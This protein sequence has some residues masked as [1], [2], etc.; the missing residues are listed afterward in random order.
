MIRPLLPGDLLYILQA[1]QWTVLLSL[2]AMGGGGALA[3]PVMLARLSRRGAL[4]LAA[5]AYIQFFQGTPLLMQVFLAFFG[6]S[7]VGVRPSPWTAASLAFSLYSSAYL[8]DI[9]RGCVQAVPRGQWEAARSLALGTPRT[10]LLVVGPQAARIAVAPTVGF[11]VQVVKSTSLASIIGFTELMRAGQFI[12]NAT[13]RPLLVYGFVACV[14][15]L[16]CWP[17]TLASR[18]L[19]A[20]FRRAGSAA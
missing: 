8:A 2:V 14:F 15:Y 9:W 20:R 6:P 17:L 12:T 5:V 18:R 7:V 13:L 16:L 1:A 11:L 3:L 10:L 4:R 19:E